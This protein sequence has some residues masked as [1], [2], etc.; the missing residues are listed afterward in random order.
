MAKSKWQIHDL[1]AENLTEEEEKK[2]E[3]EEKCHQRVGQFNLVLAHC[4]ATFPLS[5]SPSIS[6]TS[7]TVGGHSAPQCKA[8]SSKSVH[9]AQCLLVAIFPY[10]TR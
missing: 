2:E 3:K 9:T 10:I 1:P 5:V 4:Q 7:R 8:Q 6:I